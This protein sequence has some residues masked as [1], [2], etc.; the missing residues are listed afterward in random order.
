MQRGAFSQGRGSR[1]P[2]GTQEPTQSSESSPWQGWYLQ[3]TGSCSQTCGS[4]ALSRPEYASSARRAHQPAQFDAGVAGEYLFEAEFARTRN[5][6]SRRDQGR[7]SGPLELSLWSPHAVLH[8][9]AR[10][11]G[12][13]R[14]GCLRQGGSSTDHREAARPS[15]GVGDT[16]GVA[17]SAKLRNPSARQLTQLCSSMCLMQP[18]CSWILRWA[19]S[20]SADRSRWATSLVWP[21]GRTPKKKG[22][23]PCPS[24]PYPVPVQRARRPQT[25]HAWARAPP[26]PS[27]AGRLIPFE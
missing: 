20:T 14:A 15:P 23:A 21:G 7:R 5:A 9:P 11:A 19:A 8:R 6:P 3:S 1:A 2:R 25:G 24:D 12:S 13:E 26:S 16:G 10:F 4:F 27:G 22:H 18:G 17:A